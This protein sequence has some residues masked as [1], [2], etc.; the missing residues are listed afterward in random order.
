MW[1]QR[2][3]DAEQRQRERLDAMH[4]DGVHVECTPARRG[5]KVGHGTP[6]GC[7]HAGAVE[8]IHGHDFDGP[9]V[10]GCTEWAS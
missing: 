1:T 5:T 4:Y 2:R 9:L 3:Q 7:P 8:R 6:R 10:C